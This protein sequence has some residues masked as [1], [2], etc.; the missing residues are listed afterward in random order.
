[1]TLLIS[2][3]G[4]LYKKT[5]FVHTDKDIVFRDCS[6]KS[7]TVGGFAV[8]TLYS[9]PLVFYFVFCSPPFLLCMCLSYRIPDSL[10][11]KRDLR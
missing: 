10:R 1:M 2:V 8:I 6:G 11:F 7:K 9:L 4:L 5:H 3:I